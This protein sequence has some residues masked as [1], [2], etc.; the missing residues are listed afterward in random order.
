MSEKDY[1]NIIYIH[2]KNRKS[3]HYITRCSSAELIITLL[4]GKTPSPKQV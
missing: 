3:I 1:N 2:I 4:G